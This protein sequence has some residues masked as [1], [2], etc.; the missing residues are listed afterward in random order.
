M[1]DI[2]V[3]LYSTQHSNKYEHLYIYKIYKYYTVEFVFY[4]QFFYL[5]IR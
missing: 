4:Y 1:K 3:Q 5:V 2:K